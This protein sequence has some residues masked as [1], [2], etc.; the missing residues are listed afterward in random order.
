MNPLKFRCI[1][2]EE[3]EYRRKMGRFIQ[4]GI[5][6][7]RQ[8]IYLS[9]E[10]AMRRLRKSNV[11]LAVAV[12]LLQ[13][14]VIPSAFAETLATE[15]PLSQQEGYQEYKSVTVTAQPNVGSDIRPYFNISCHGP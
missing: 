5:S 11:A 9:K 14:S 10:E 1:Y 7:G 3:E 2:T 4:I 8:I 12:A 13:W 6:Q 15:R